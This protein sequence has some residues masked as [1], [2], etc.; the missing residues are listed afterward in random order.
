MQETKV[1]VC[2]FSWSE[3]RSSL[4]SVGPVA[5]MI[6]SSCRAVMTL[7]EAGAISLNQPLSITW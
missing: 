2:G 6:R 3:G 1:R 5:E 4:P 7:A